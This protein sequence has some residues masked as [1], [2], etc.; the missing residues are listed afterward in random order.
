M[1]HSDNFCGPRDRDPRYVRLMD[2]GDS[3]C[4]EW[5]DAIADRTGCWRCNV[6]PGGWDPD[7]GAVAAT[8]Q[9]EFVP[10]LL[11]ERDD[12]YVRSAFADEIVKARKA[13]LA[14]A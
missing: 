4:V 13:A 9:W 2:P 11:G 1:M 3:T 14:H 7:S 5:Y 10:Y 12:R 6:T 8:E